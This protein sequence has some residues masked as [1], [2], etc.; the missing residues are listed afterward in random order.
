M[1][2]ITLTLY[3]IRDS[4]PS[5]NPLQRLYRLEKPSSQYP[6]QLE[7]ILTGDE[8]E[9]YVSALR[10]E[11]LVWLVDYLDSVRPG[12]TVLRSFLITSVGPRWP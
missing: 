5:S 10:G 9:D 6:N 8:Y 7:S 11:G 2:V 3:T 12:F 4:S 1:R